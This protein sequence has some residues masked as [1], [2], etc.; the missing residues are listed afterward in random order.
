LADG[1]KWKNVHILQ[2]IKA[3]CLHFYAFARPEFGKLIE[4][5]GYLLSTEFLYKVI[6]SI[7]KGVPTSFD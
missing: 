4:G 7:F 6:D 3:A 1:L 5:C 2:Q